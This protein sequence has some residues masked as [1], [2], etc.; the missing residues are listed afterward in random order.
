MN[1][2]GDRDP[3]GPIESPCISRIRAA[4]RWPTSRSCGRRWMVEVSLRSPARQPTRW[5]T[6]RRRGYGFRLPVA[7][8]CGQRVGNGPASSD[9]PCL[10]ALA[11]PGPAGVPCL[12]SAEAVSRASARGRELAN[13]V[14]LRG[15]TDAAGNAVPERA[16]N[17]AAERGRPL[18]TAPPATDSLGAVR[19]RW[20][21][22]GGDTQHAAPLSAR[23]D[24][25]VR[26]VVVVASMVATPAPP[27]SPRHH[28]SRPRDP[29]LRTVPVSHRIALVLRRRGAERL[30]HIGVLQALAE[31][32]H[33]RPSLYAGTSIGALVAGAVASGMPN[34]AMGAKRGDASPTAR[35]VSAQPRGM[36]LERRR[37]SSIYAGE[38]LRALCEGNVPACT[39]TGFRCRCSSTPSMW[40]VGRRPCGAPGL[41]DVR[42]ATRC[43]HRVRYRGSSHPA[44]W[45]VRLCIDGGTIDNLPVQIAGLGADV[46][47]IACRCRQHRPLARRETC[48]RRGSPRSTCCAGHRDDAC[49]AARAGSRSGRDRRCC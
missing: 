19:A 5:A 46:G 30:R 45:A 3:V 11:L 47:S 22:P 8:G 37:A 28:Q 21:L 43:T 1:R 35:P 13:P 20:T 29:I 9:R 12:R 27:P 39:S 18:R 4:V 2:S 14:I 49:A 41:R 16:H 17:V 48:C 42:S 38:P 36:L 33:S 25:I 23:V 15:G 32:G 26:P 31:A 24:G 10:H 44:P 6:S 40:S 34:S 7:S